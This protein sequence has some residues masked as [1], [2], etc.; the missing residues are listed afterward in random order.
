MA[1]PKS[2]LSYLI[3]HLILFDGFLIAAQNNAP[4]SLAMPT[5]TVHI[6]ITGSSIAGTGPDRMDYIRYWGRTR[7]CHWEERSDVAISSQPRSSAKPLKQSRCGATTQSARFLVKI[8]G[9]PTARR[10]DPSASDDGRIEQTRT[11]TTPH[12]AV[13][14][15]TPVCNPTP[16][17]PRTTP[18][19]STA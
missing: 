10:P 17:T 1:T 5:W 13:S 4:E 19:P 14:P 3:Y 6:I 16:A 8:L 11:P 18:A 7:R 12:A 9:V 15:S 2:P